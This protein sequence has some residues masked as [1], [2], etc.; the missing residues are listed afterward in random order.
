MLRRRRAAVVVV[1]VVTLAAVGSGL[2]AL[3]SEAAAQGGVA[4]GAVAVEPARSAPGSGAAAWPG[5]ASRVVVVSRGETVWD[6]A[7]A[8]APAGEHR[9]VYVAEVLA[10]NDVDPARLLPGTVLRLP[11]R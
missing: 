2:S 10:R 8:H 3:R 7:V 4:P 1:V 9:Q 6:L 5:T 11:R